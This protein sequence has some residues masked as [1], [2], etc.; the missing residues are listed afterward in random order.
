M[1]GGVEWAF[2]TRVGSDGHAYDWSL[3]DW[4]PRIFVGSSS[5]ALPLA[6]HISK[7]IESE[8]MTPRDVGRRCIHAGSNP[9]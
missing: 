7:V 8:R 6:N 2:R 9:N 4:K 1:S 5:E 3:M